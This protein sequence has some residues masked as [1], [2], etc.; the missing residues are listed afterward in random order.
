M[1]KLFLLSFFAITL[2]AEAQNNVFPLPSGN[3]GI[4]TT[5][6]STEL[7]VIGEVR[8]TKGVFTNS[9]VGNYPL[10]LGEVVDT[11]E[12]R[13]LRFYVNSS[14]ISDQ[15]NIGSSW[16]DSNNKHRMESFFYPNKSFTSFYTYTGAEYFKID[17]GSLGANKMYM[18]LPKPDSRIVIGSWGSYL[19]EHKFVVK[20]G[21]AMIEG[22]ILTNSNVGIGTNSF[23][24]GSDTYRLSID[25]KVR[26]HAV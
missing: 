20:S 5:I 1:K 15:L 3:V 17:H 6:P 2:I 18:H 22:N 13:N 8:A 9:I 26:A 21:S 23:T 12:K 16:Y 14:A 7:E 24:D 19:P 11:G 4:G 10:Q 25:G